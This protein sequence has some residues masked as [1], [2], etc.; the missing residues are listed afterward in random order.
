MNL[1]FFIPKK[2][3]RTSGFTFVKLWQL[4]P[5]NNSLS[6]GFRLAIGSVE[7]NA[8]ATH[9][10]TYNAVLRYEEASSKTLNY[11]Y[12]YSFSR[13]FYSSLVRQKPRRCGNTTLYALRGQILWRLYSTCSPRCRPQSTRFILTLQIPYS[14]IVS[15]MLIENL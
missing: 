1:A 12:D 3:E 2:K 7:Q 10:V 11:Q 13:L 4:I 15:S 8:V 6:T 14:A 9:V 5:V